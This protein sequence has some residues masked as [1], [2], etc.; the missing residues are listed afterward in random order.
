[1]VSIVAALHD[2]G[3]A[4]LDVKPANIVLYS[5]DSDGLTKL[6]GIDLHHAVRL[7]TALESLPAVTWTYA[8]P[9]IA[10]KAA[11][12]GIKV[13]AEQCDLWSL[14]I[15][16]MEIFDKGQSFFSRT[17][18]KLELQSALR[19]LTTE[20]IEAWTRS[21][22][23]APQY[24]LLRQFLKQ[25][26]R[27]S[28]EERTPAVRLI[29]VIDGSAQRGI[30]D[31]ESKIDNVAE[32]VDAVGGKVDQLL[33]ITLGLQECNAEVQKALE[34]TAK[35]V[36]NQQSELQE[37]LQQLNESMVQVV[38]E[39]NNVA[40]AQDLTG[41]LSNMKAAFEACTQQCAF[42]ATE[43]QKQA[44]SAALQVIPCVHSCIGG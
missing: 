37:T 20:R 27:I 33:Q 35:L 28:P 25:T 10:R 6:V 39:A 41:P 29:S 30:T 44:I 7:H 12:E 19:A 43:L 36:S 22:F 11:G 15:A 8:A 16:V 2:A 26:L 5:S 1:V 21:R 38:H 13:Y 42:A 9:E 23:G 4:W 31:L 17:D 34:H 14:G 24:R 3:Y 40:N 18:D 32:K